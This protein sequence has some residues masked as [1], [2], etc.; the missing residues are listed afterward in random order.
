MD[1]LAS[2]G[3]RDALSLVAGVAL[4]SGG[5]LQYPKDICPWAGCSLRASVSLLV[6]GSE[7]SSGPVG[8]VSVEAH[9]LLTL[10]IVDNVAGLDDKGL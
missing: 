3:L 10:E 2:L 9:L 8:R 7:E 4:T 5:V 6:N 1:A